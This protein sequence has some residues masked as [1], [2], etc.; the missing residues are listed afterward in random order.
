MKIERVPLAEPDLRGQEGE[1]LA[2]CVETNWV[3]SAGRYVTEFEQRLAAAVDRKHAVAMVN[4]TAAL[5]MALTVAGVGPGAY[6][7]VPDFTFA[8]SAN[9]VYH[10]GA[11]PFIVDVSA[12]H[13]SLD[14]ELV[15]EVLA[16]GD[17]RVKAVIAVH[18]LGTPADMD[19]LRKLCEIY[20]VALIEDAAGALGATYRRRPAGA[21]GDAAIFS[22]NGNK[23]V[24][25]GGG[26]MYLTD[27]DD[28]ADRARALSTQARSGARYQYFAVGHNYR[29]TNVNAAIGVAQMERLDEMLAAKRRIAAVYDRALGNRGDLSPMPR[30]TWAESACW[31]YS[32]LCA[33]RQDADDLV[34]LLT[35]HK[36]EARLFWESLSAQAPYADAPRRLNGTTHRLSGCV[37]SL[38]CSSHLTAE[39][40]ERVLAVLSQWRGGIIEDAA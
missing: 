29:M 15:E 6:V 34:K 5:H 37:V 1:Y 17:A 20:N 24:T 38:P 16:R 18:A 8:A 26:G 10:S 36:I 21:L 9:A 4:G 39:Q 32:V 27:R 40:Q 12:A 33:S 22:F 2:A 30:P 11:I 19:P 7:I 35:E 31:L 23:T 3:S 14:S 28:W 13:W 25:A